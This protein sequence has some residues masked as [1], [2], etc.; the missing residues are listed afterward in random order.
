MQGHTY[1]LKYRL[2]IP[3]R[4]CWDQSVWN[5]ICNKLLVGPKGQKEQC[6]NA[7]MWTLA[8]SRTVYHHTLSTET[9][10]LKGCSGSIKSRAILS[11]CLSIQL[12]HL[13]VF[14]SY[15]MP[16][17]LF[18]LALKGHPFEEYTGSHAATSVSMFNGG[19]RSTRSKQK[20]P[21]SSDSY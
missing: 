11:W 21:E 5:L 9:V 4:P 7:S 8:C 14:G 12:F 13:I 19:W 6:S 2:A 16:L 3:I 18:Q 1:T 20:P 17:A 15:P 10:L